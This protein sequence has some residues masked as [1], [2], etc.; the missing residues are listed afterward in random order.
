MPLK[1][2]GQYSIYS[3]FFQFWDSKKPLNEVQAALRNVL[4][5]NT[6]TQYSVI[7]CAEEIL[8]SK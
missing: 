2:I 1:N 5:R 4:P 7:H 8:R 6:F 3:T